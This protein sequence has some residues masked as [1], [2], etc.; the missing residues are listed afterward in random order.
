MENKKLH[1]IVSA[2]KSMYEEV[3]LS[4]AT[5]SHLHKAANQH[6]EDDG[7][8]DPADWAEHLDN[9]MDSHKKDSKPGAHKGFDSR[10]KSQ[11]QH[12]AK[13]LQH[14]IKGGG[15]LDGGTHHTNTLTALDKG[16][17]LG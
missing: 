4:A 16:S 9:A 2:Y 1:K 12:L 15:E 7:E 3:N 11:Q 6:H 10:P 8:G 5:K 13:A 17:G 14:H